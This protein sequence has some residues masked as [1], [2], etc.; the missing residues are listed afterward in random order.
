MQLTTTWLALTKGEDMQERGIW[1]VLIMILLGLRS[2]DR[3][4]SDERK[5]LPAAGNMGFD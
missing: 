5:G 2:L 1:Y 4:V 3:Q